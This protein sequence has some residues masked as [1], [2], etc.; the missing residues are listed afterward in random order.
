[1]LAGAKYLITG[2]GDAANPP[3]VGGAFIKSQPEKEIPDIGNTLCINCN[4]HVHGR[5]GV[6]LKMDF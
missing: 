4:A 3:C 1:M 6:P 2:T 5:E